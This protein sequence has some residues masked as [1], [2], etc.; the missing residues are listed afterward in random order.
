MVWNQVSGAAHSAVAG[1]TMAFT[2]AKLAEHREK[3]RWLRRTVYQPLYGR[4]NRRR[5]EWGFYR[6][7]WDHWTGNWRR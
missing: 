4:S 2:T 1:I 7:L 5:T 3:R 6:S